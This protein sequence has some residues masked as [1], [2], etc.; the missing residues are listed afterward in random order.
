MLCDDIYDHCYARIVQGWDGRDREH[1]V[2][3]CVY[4]NPWTQHMNCVHDFSTLRTDGGVRCVCVCVWCMCSGKRRGRKNMVYCLLLSLQ[5]T[6]QSK[7]CPRS[8]L[9]W[10]FPFFFL[11]FS[12]LFCCFCLCTMTHKRLYCYNNQRHKQ[13]L[14]QAFRNRYLMGRCSNSSNA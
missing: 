10:L 4:S 9:F 6:R 5:I 13:L 8:L 11:F 12:L 3:V 14:L 1:C 2:C 7:M